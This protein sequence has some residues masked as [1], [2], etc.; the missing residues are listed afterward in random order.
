MIT[1]ELTTS[2]F[3]ACDTAGKLRRLDGAGVEWVV[4]EGLVPYLEGR[5]AATAAAPAPGTS[6]RPRGGGGGG[7]GGCRR[8]RLGG[9]CPL[10]GGAGRHE[11]PRCGHRRRHGA[12][13]GVAA[14][15]SA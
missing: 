11:G 15:T 4:S 1:E 8:G 14:G 5:A 13:G 2:R 7:G 6:P 3:G 10:S 12:G 9:F